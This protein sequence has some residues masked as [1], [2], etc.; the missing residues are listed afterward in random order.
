MVLLLGILLW[1]LLYGPELK[2]SSE[3][4]PD[5]IRRTVSLAVLRP[6]VWVEGRLG[7]TGLIDN[8]SSALGRRPNEA[9]GGC[10]GVDPLPSVPTPSNPTA[11]PQHDTKIRE[12][13]TVK[14][15]RVVVVGDS[16]AQGIGS[17]AERVFKPSLVNVI[18]QG[19]ISTGL[20]RPD[21]FNWPAQMRL[22]VDRSRPDLTIVMLGEN[23]AQSLVT[24]E[25]QPVAQVGT[26]DF[27][28][29]YEQRVR[30]F[31]RLA[32][33]QGGHVIWVGLPNPRDTRRWDF[34]E[35][36][37]GAFQAVADELPNVAF[38]DTWNTFA[39]PGGGY[40]A[41]YQDG[42]QLTLVRADD[43]V[44]FN[45]DGYT[46]LMRLVARFGTQQFQMD[47]RTYEG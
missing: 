21:Y 6:V 47:P 3:A 43:G 29:A 23:D 11:H 45:A 42:K 25:G 46:I 16:L 20:S 32:T 10:G 12:P 41:Y 34:I 8:A 40:T 13:T 35:R 2:R 31:A 39:A 33:S 4:Q 17:F 22:I 44:H 24:P 28:P 1:G 30:S 19:R 5:G 7:L 38:F 18:K 14:P 37:N 9:V 15:L 27:P 26:G 36:Q